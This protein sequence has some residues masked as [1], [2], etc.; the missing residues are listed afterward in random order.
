MHILI[1]RYVLLFFLLNS[2]IIIILICEQ[3][4]IFPDKQEGKSGKTIL[5]WAIENLRVQLVGFLLKNQANIQAETFAGKTPLHFLLKSSIIKQNNQHDSTSTTSLTQSNKSKIYK[6]IR[7][8]IEYCNEKKLSLDAI[9]HVS[10]D[11]DT[12]ENES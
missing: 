1:F 2:Y 9:S 7:M 3:K 8:S 4:I 6:I 5:H 11:T 10:D 12:S